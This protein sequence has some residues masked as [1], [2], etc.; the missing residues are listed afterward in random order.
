M[1]VVVTRRDR[2]RDFVEGAIRQLYRERYEAYLSSFAATI[3]AELGPSGD[4]ECAAGI[5]FGNEA[6]FSECYLDR[7]IEYLLEDYMVNNVHRDRIVEVCHLAAVTPGR[8]LSFVQKLIELLRGMDAEWAV[9]TAT[10]PLRN[11]LQRSRL[12]MIE[13]G[14]AERS[15]VPYPESWGRYFEHDP[16]IMAVGR[17]AFAPRHFG[18]LPSAPLTANAR[19]F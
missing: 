13:L 2:L 18:A 7:P 16:R 9:F 4:I 1:L 11:L 12:T 19:I 10:K 17:Q 3:V 14:A 5:R 8:S 15:R 6:F